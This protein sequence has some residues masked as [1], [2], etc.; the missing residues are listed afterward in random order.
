MPTHD[1][2][3]G[4]LL[5]SYELRDDPGREHEEFVNDLADARRHLKGKADMVVWAT[6]HDQEGEEIA[7]QQVLV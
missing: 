1:P 3:G 7:D 6:L 5:L 2:F 4:Q